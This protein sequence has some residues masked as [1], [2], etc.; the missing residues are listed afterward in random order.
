M[1]GEQDDTRTPGERIGALVLAARRARKWTQS[2]LA[3]KAG[4]TRETVYRV[5]KGRMPTGDVA[6]RLSDALGM[7]RDELDL[8]VRETDHIAMHPDLTLLRERRRAC[9]LKLRECAAAAGVSM[10]T[11]SRFERGVERNRD[12][13]AFDERGRPVRMINAGLAEVL[14]FPSVEALDTYWRTGRG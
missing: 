6:V 12:L 9:G 1:A 4:V 13:A 10:P 3:T 5:E 14:G 2:R 11:L 7:D 8:K